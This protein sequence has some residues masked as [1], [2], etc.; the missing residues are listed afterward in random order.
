MENEYNTK[1]EA[2]DHFLPK[3]QYPFISIHFFNLAPMCYKCN[4]LYKSRK[5]PIDINKTG[6]YKKVFYPFSNYEKMD[7]KIEIQNIQLDKIQPSEID[8][9]NSLVGYND[10]VES[11]E[12]IFSIKSRHRSIYVGDSF[13]W[14]EEV[15]I[16]TNNFGETYNSHK[17][18]LENNY[19]CNENFMKLALLE[20]CERKSIL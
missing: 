2:Y 4:S 11:W 13:N 20:A 3:E 14:L 6:N 1:K 19:F 17:A 5:N 8:I 9:K 18:N 10:E 16:C 7:I 15:R 12:E